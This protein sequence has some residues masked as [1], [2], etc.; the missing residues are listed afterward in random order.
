[1]KH[2]YAH[3][4][5]R[6]TQFRLFKQIK[7]PKAFLQMPAI[8]RYLLLLTIAGLFL[9]GCQSHD[10]I[11]LITDFGAKA[12]QEHVNT[13]AIQEAI[14]QASKDGGGVVIV[15][16]GTFVTGTIYMKDSVT[17]HVRKG[18]TLKGSCNLDDYPVNE[19]QTYRSYTERYSKKSLIFAEDAQYITL[20]GEGVIDGNGDC[21]GLH[22]E[23]SDKPL[24]IRLVSCQHVEVRDLKLQNAR[25]WMQHYLNCED[26][27]IDNLSVFNFG[28]TTNDGLNIDGCR[29]VRVSN[30]YI[31]SHDDAIALK[32]TGPAPCE[33]ITITNC[34][35]QSHCHGIKMGTESTGGFKRINIS[36]CAIRASEIPAHGV[37]RVQ[38]I[39]AIALEM[40]DGGTMEDIHVNNITAEH[41]FAPI[42]IKLGDR[43]RKHKEDA[44]EPGPGTLRDVTISNLTAT[45]AGPFSSSITGYPG[46]YVENVTLSNIRISHYG[47]GKADEIMDKVPENK[48]DYPEIKMF[49]NDWH[50]PRLPSYGFFVR[51]VKNLTMENVTLELQS[52]DARKPVYME[53]VFEVT[54]D[55]TSTR[56]LPERMR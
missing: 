34:V 3:F 13:E 39:T 49:G 5:A 45:N 2:L 16:Q 6:S 9:S 27:S 38:V 53:D 26:L 24:G 35:A 51:H 30:C 18:A 42:F 14:D 54:A 15:P 52:P 36:N 28:N 40:V 19:L 17:L 41:V 55:E 37:D 56:I 33:D 11:Y 23:G 47:G 10:G 43:D 31:H 46:H 1:M 4:F 8:T 21:E 25:L 22:E 44:K 50:G 20:R 12:G 29:D 32:S 7:P 48:G